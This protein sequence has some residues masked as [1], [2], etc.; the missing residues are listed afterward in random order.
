MSKQNKIIL[1]IVIVIIVIVV[2]VEV[3][4]PAPNQYGL[5]NL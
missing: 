2:I 4:K 3:L 1:A 5:I